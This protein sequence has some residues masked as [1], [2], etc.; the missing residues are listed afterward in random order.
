M[1]P[2]ARKAVYLS[3]NKNGT[4]LIVTYIV[5]F[6]IY[7]LQEKANTNTLDAGLYSIYLTQSI[8]YTPFSLRA[9][10]GTQRRR[11][12]FYLNNSTYGLPDIC[13]R[14]HARMYIYVPIAQSE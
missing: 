11:E 10:K 9:E 1:A 6:T 2:S 13:T 12:R 7:Y 5:S 14:I 3:S 8:M 4:H